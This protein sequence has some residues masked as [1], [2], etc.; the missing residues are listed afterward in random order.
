MVEV[1]RSTGMATD[2]RKVGD[3]ALQKEQFATAAE[4]F[5]QESAIYR[6]K[7]QVQAALAE[8]ARAA[9]VSTELSLYVSRSGKNAPSRKL[10]RLEP[11]SGCYLGAFIDRDDNLKRLPFDSQTHGDVDEFQKLVTKPHASYFM[12]RTYG[13]PF[14]LKWARYLKQRGAFPHIAWEPKSLTDVKDDAYLKKFVD[15]MV[16][17]DFPVILRFASEMNGEW[18]PYHS[19]PQAYK[20]AFRLVYEATRRAPQVAMM[21]CP[22]TVPS[23]GVEDYYPGD[24]AVDWVG[25]NFYS[26]PFLDNDRTRPGEK[27]H[28]TDLLQ[29]VYEQFS[30]R[31]PIAVGEWAASRQ[32]SLSP[33]PS[34]E[35]AKTKISQ[36]Y[37]ALPTRFPR[38]KMVNWYDSNNLLEARPGRQLNNYQVTSPPDVL[39]RYRE[40]VSNPHYL[41][42]Y[43]A[44]SPRSFERVVGRTSV[45]R[46]DTIRIFLKTYDQH[47]K[48]YFQCNGEIILATDEPLHWFLSTRT[49]KS[50]KNVLDIFVYDS[51]DRFVSKSRAVFDVVPP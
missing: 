40:A 33:M 5:R 26:V 46:E 21:W 16:S 19:D 44:V 41:D 30:D 4:A 27:I 37:S 23:Q 50:G 43:K 32:S 51:K 22:N 42:D 15:D 2:W 39:A 25:V 11:S 47:P 48:V 6:S 7:G 45:D 3:Y 29:G 38:V 14:P 35:F 10:E 17:L 13:Q 36:L 24:D 12:Y 31:K 18:T 28:P 9:Q 49:W 20:K 34:G 8:E 1:A